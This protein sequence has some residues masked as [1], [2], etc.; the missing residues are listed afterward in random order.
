MQ[1]VGREFREWIRLQ[2]PAGSIPNSTNDDRVH[3]ETAAASAEVNLYP[4]TDERE[5][6]ELRITRRSDGASS[7][8]LH[9]MLDDLARAQEL[10]GEMADALADMT[11]HTVAR[12]L[13]CCTSAM[14]TSLFASKMNEVVQSLSLDYEFSAMSLERALTHEGD[15][16]VAILLA[17]QVG[18]LRREMAQAHP[19]TL[20]FEIPAKVFGSYDAGMAVRLLMHAMRDERGQRE[21]ISL[22]PARHHKDRRRILAI[23]LFALRRGSRLGWRLYERGVSTAEG[24]VIKPRVNFRDIEDLIETLSVRGID[25]AQL[26]A[27]GIA[28]PGVTQ[29]G[30]VHL[31]GFDEGGFDLGPHL[32]ERFKVPVFVDNNCNVA[33]VACYVSQDVHESIV[34]FRQEFG[35]EAGGLGTV[36]QGHLLR[37]RA[38]LAGE[39]KFFEQRFSYTA[40]SYDDARWSAEGMLEIALHVTLAAVALMAPD[41]VFLAVDTVDDLAVLRSALADVLGE[42]YVPALYMVNDYVER[43]YL[44]EM[45]LCVQRLDIRDRESL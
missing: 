22:K 36:L 29:R 14:T 38:H 1:Q 33:A 20:T 25:V 4:Y 23:T 10:F 37:G 11:E 9:F 31:P 2:R 6:C 15:G 12:V 43:V 35:H 27:V 7:F 26:D 39:P 17:P 30:I 41:A 8:F 42:E 21:A 3:F 45:A 16:Y 34:F 28:V 32:M 13:L 18:H 40:G 5:M 44:G 19:D 24:C